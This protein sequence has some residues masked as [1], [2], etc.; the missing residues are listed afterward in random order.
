MLVEYVRD[1]CPHCG[2][3]VSAPNIVTRKLAGVDLD[4]GRIPNLIVNGE[5]KHLTPQQCSLLGALMRRPG[6]VMDSVTLCNIMGTNSTSEKFL[7]VQLTSI[8]KEI[9]GCEEVKIQN[10]RGIGYSIDVV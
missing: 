8:R 5:D 7:G 9:A 6:T 2:N 3:Q 4:T 10:H 1:I